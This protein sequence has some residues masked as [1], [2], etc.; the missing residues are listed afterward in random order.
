MN[1]LFNNGKIIFLLFIFL[2]AFGVV[3]LS[4]MQRQG[5]PDVAVNVASISVVYPSASAQIV[6]ED[7]LVPLESAIEEIESVDEYQTTA[8]DSW[9][10]IYVTFDP[11]ADMNEVFSALKEQVNQVDLPEDANEP[12]VQKFSVAGS[13]EFILSLTGYED[14]ELLYFSGESAAHQLEN[15]EGVKSVTPQNG[16][17]AE[18]VISFDAEALEEH[19]ISR[20]QAEETIRSAQFLLPI[21]SIGEEGSETNIAVERELT[22]VHDIDSIYLTE[23]V[24]VKDVAD[25]DEQFNN[26]NH[27]NRVGFRDEG[28]EELM[29]SRALLYAV[30][31]DSEADILDVE[32][33]IMEFIHDYN[34]PCASSIC[35]TIDIDPDNVG[36]LDI[37]YSQADETRLQIE[38]I[39]QSI[40]GKPIEDLGGFAFLG[41]LLG[42]LSFVVILLLIFMNARV[43]ILAALSIPLSLFFA[44]IYLNLAGI[45]LNTLVLFS[46]VL[47]VGLVVD[48]TI[49]FLEALQRFKEQGLTGCEAAAKTFS[50]V[51]LGVFLAVATNIL[52]FVPFGVVSGF[53]GEIIKYIPATVIPAMVASMII[54]AVFFTPMAARILKP[55]KK[56]VRTEDPELA[57]TWKVGRLI[58]DEIF[59]LL[60]A[61]RLKVAL[62]ILVF[63]IVIAFPFAIAAA[64][65]Q[66]KEVEVVQFSQPEDSE[67][68][69]LTANVSDDIMFDEAVT[70]VAVPVQDEIAMYE[71]VGSFSYY[72][73]SGNSFTMLIQLLPIADRKD[74]DL[75]TSDEVASAMNEAFD[76]MDL[77]ADL[78][79]STSG[80]GPPQ[81]N[82]PIRVRIYADQKEVLDQ[83]ISAVRE[84]LES[85]DGIDRV[86]DTI[87]DANDTS[88]VRFA[89]D[90]NELVTQNAFM[91][92]STVADRIAEQDLGEVEIDGITYE[93]LSVPEDPAESLKEIRN[94]PILTPEGMLYEQTVQQLEAEG[95]DPEEAGIEKP[96]DM[97][98]R[99]FVAWEK[100]I[101]PE[102]ISRVN[103]RRFAEISASVEEGVDPIELQAALV[104]YLDQE[105]VESFGLEMDA[106]D[107]EGEAD[108]IG[109]SFG[110]LF[111]A[112]AIAIFMIY[113][114]LVAFLRSFLEPFIILFAIPLG[115]AG[116]FVAVWLTTG[117]LGFLELLGVVAMAGIVVNVTILLID[118]ANQLKR[119]GKTPAEAI[120]T[121]IAVRFRPIVL[122]QLTAFGSLIP[123]VF[124]SPFWKGLAA[125]IIFGIVSS[126]LLS[127]FVTP[128]LYQWANTLNNLAVSIPKRIPRLRWS[129][130]TRRK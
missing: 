129:L 38:E 11:K 124:L 39:T 73:Q 17:T 58:G 99:D 102:I 123:L 74:A 71:E 77:K 86:E 36:Q 116:V 85:T 67:F 113:L 109:E 105:K 95:V 35:A 44:A 59:W 27:Y 25:V 40:F 96:K 98:F 111:I 52:V 26:N 49:V 89:L 31:I 8:G 14:T 20:A 91:I 21:G 4:Q 70:E 45:E 92:A 100:E 34:A 117:Q 107:F 75:R 112:L 16:V 68:I 103:G 37:V 66:S 128:I 79:A 18:I 65:I 13:G 33:R 94:I 53:F 3:S 56:P 84:F 57:G 9:G 122:T 46:M 7:I 90:G 48:P 80:E 51:G 97:Y 108:A 127:L 61:G 32:E 93:V 110:D 83:A 62:R 82:F 47:T 6:E 10:S 115:L 120:A 101:E 60:G 78:K 125:S 118:Y 64:L 5:F 76:E 2:V 63:A 88:N 130:P 15:I 106:I 72:T 104:E 22:S 69:L 114:L 30:K 23:G 1:L 43:A 119:D 81:D 41:Y 28:E 87:T 54:P 12:N 126:A 42:G 50:T 19:G 24:Q 121:S 29:I 55:K